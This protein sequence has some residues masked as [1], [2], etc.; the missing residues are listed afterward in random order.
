MLQLLV[1]KHG[2]IPAQT[3]MAGDSHM[4]LNGA[5]QC[6]MGT[7]AALYGYESP[8]ALLDC[9]P[10]IAIDDEDWTSIRFIRS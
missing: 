2:L 8:Q 10:D 5:R 1:E 9:C 3:L 6:G 4:D 7:A